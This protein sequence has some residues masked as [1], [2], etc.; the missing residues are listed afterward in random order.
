L[1]IDKLTADTVNSLYSCSVYD[2]ISVEAEFN[3]GF[4]LSTGNLT[5]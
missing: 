5:L 2:L 1:V 4:E 3:I